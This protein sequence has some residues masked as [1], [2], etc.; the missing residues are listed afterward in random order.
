MSDPRHEIQAITI[1]YVR[2]SCGFE[3]RLHELKNKSD[4]D[5]AA[6]VMELFENHKIAM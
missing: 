4:E 5:L 6:E 2:C 1:V 3:A